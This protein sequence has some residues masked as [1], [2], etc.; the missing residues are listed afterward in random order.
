MREQDNTWWRKCL[1]WQGISKASLRV[2][3]MKQKWD[4]LHIPPTENTEQWR[5]YFSPLQAGHKILP[6]FL[7]ESSASCLEACHMGSP[8]PC[9]SLT[10][11]ARPYRSCEYRRFPADFENWLTHSPSSECWEV[12]I[13]FVFVLFSWKLRRIGQVILID[14]ISTRKDEKTYFLSTWEHIFYFV[15]TYRIS[16]Q[17]ITCA[18]HHFFF[19][20]CT[21]LCPFHWIFKYQS[22]CDSHRAAVCA[23]S[24]Q[25]VS[26]QG[27]L[28]VSLPSRWDSSVFVLT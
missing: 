9:L 7:E 11:L 26:S 6:S 28:K 5:R 17:H 19:L 14:A 8:T 3:I 24:R 25:L 18:H 20:F 27:H 22:D 12:L 21:F 13:F 2:V 1:M 23:L 15:K 16:L 4:Q 10:P